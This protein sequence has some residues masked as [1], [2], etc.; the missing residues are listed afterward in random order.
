MALDVGTLVNVTARIAAGASPRLPFG[1]GLL[2]T[3]NDDLPAGGNNKA[4]L[5]TSISAVGEV[6]DSDSD[7]YKDAAVWFSADPRPQ[8]LYIGR[9]ASEDIG[10]VI[11]G[12]T[13]D[14]AAGDSPLNANNG[15]F[16]VN[17]QTVTVDLTSQS[18]YADIATTVETAL[19][20]LGGVF[21]GVD[22][23]YDAANDRFVLTLASG[24]VITDG[25][26]SD[27]ADTSDTD[28]ATALGMSA[29]AEPTYLQGS[30]EE[31]IAEG[32]QAMVDLA[33]GGDPRCV[34]LGR[35]APLTYGT[36]TVDTRNALAVHA[37][38]SAMH[39]AMFITEE[40]ALI[41]GDTTSH[42]ATAFDAQRQYVT[43]L[44][45]EAGLRSDIGLMAEMSAQN[46]DQ[47]NSIITPHPKTL[48]GVS[49]VDLSPNERLELKRQRCNAYARVGSDGALLGGWTSRTGYWLD[50]V[51]W[52]DW[53]QNELELTIWDG[54][55]RARR[56]TNALL[57]DALT[58]A[59]RKGVRS[60]GI[61]P[62]RSVSADTKA[63][64]AST[65]GDVNFDGVLPLGYLIYI[66]TT[67]T[68]SDLANRIGRFNIWCTG[69]EAIHEVFGDLEFTN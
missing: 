47:P 36:P 49:P 55:R 16:M 7:I 33:V 9:W 48:P 13:V 67:R 3:V 26:F 60:G 22:F 11:R 38:A 27:T 20:A 45:S 63:N 54:M 41:T 43:T 37:Q 2:V 46:F 53:M 4:Q 15:T 23:V 5:F 69:S 25:V 66:P 39:Y 64:I 30:D 1:R 12:G 44:Y 65:T 34:M 42:K 10:T 62:G 31:T 8:G 57:L 51:W 32:V 24:A 17:G 18:T 14:V 35:D 19:A 6:V 59:M 56:F 21:A 50:A 28:I 58:T 29:S 61:Q 40:A 52:L 68:S